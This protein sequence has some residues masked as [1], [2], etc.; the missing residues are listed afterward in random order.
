MLL[1][2]TVVLTASVS[3]AANLAVRWSVNGIP[4]G[5]TTVGTISVDG[6][7]TAPQILPLP[8]SVFVDA[9]S[10]ADSTKAVTATITIISDLSVAIL[11][12]AATAELGAQQTFQATV[13]SAGQPSTTVTWTASGAGCSGAACGAVSASGVFTAP[14]I[15]PSP[16]TMVL[17][18]TS[19]ADP[20]KNATAGITITSRFSF[21]ANGPASIEEGAS[22]DLTA[23][24]TPLPDSN[25]SRAISWK[26]SGADCGTAA[27]G[28]LATSGS[29]ASATYT[30]PAAA[31]SPNVIMIIATPV[32]DPWKA[33]LIRVTIVSAA[34]VL[35]TLAP[36]SATLTI[37]HRKIFTAQVLN[38]ANTMLNWQVNGVSGGNG[39][40]GRICVVDSNPCQVV[41]SASAASV[42]YLAPAAVP[43]PN[44]VNLRV[45]SQ[46]DTTKSASSN[47]TI[48]PHV[49]VSVAPPSVSLP[50]GAKQAFT[51]S[52]AGTSNQQVIWNVSGPACTGAGAPCGTIDA[53]GLY[54]AP[55]IAPVPNT[56]SVVATSSEDTS[57]TG[58]AAVTITLQP[59][60]L[61]L[62]PSSITA[63]AAGGF[64]LRVEGGNFISSSPGPGSTVLI[65]GIARGTVCS[66]T[67][68]CTTTLAAPDLA[69]AANLS[70]GVQNPDGSMSNTAMFVV[71]PPLASADI[72]P[73]TPGA[74][75]ASRDITV[76]ELSTNSS[77]SPPENVN[78]NIIA[79]G[80]FQPAIGSCLL[81]GGSVTLARPSSGTATADLCAFSLSGLD[82]SLAFTLGGPSPNDIAIVGKEPLGLGIIHLT[83][84]VPSTARTG[85]RTL[86]I[87]NANLDLTAASGAIE[88]R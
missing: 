54:I 87:Q 19:M 13:A 40:V 24:L 68:V 46:A 29:G 76:A 8:A 71:V 74:P 73:L 32:A 80:P 70:A 16:L 41:T 50:P 14:Q 78:L 3:N 15:L 31:P 10:L 48:R 7:F 47:I 6:I 4:G 83:L 33:V 35:V 56:L 49:V 17:T 60:I 55:A 82:P 2:S 81:G 62:R 58:S 86:F 11:P 61:T 39:T 75:A 53:S 72:I 38:S 51:A 18:A 26:I 84:Q 37:H 57:R 88:V 27:C 43:S 20:S 25:P 12:D 79:I 23:T 34:G 66:S 52:V 44:P 5:N 69:I 77:S 42:D 28:S 36:G 59:T 63:G 1:G 65:G 45:T 67:S 30:A 22:A 85:A 21:S 9:I 64:T